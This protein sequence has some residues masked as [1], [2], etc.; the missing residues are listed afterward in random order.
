[1]LLYPNLLLGLPSRVTLL[2]PPS[3]PSTLQLGDSI[4]KKL[5]TPH[6][7]HPALKLT[8]LQPAGHVLAGSQSERRRGSRDSTLVHCN[9]VIAL[10][11]HISGIF[12]NAVYI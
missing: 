7:R 5:H 10:H 12:S 9:P 1:M 8:P 2:Q 6:T 3:T 4:G 11:S